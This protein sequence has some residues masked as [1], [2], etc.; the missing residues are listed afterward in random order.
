MRFIL[1]PLTGWPLSDDRKIYL[2]DRE[3]KRV[4]GLQHL[5][6]LSLPQDDLP[7]DELVSRPYSLPD[8]GIPL[9]DSPLQHSDGGLQCDD[10]SGRPLHSLV[11]LEQPDLRHHDPRV[12]KSKKR[13]R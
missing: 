2:P 6:L 4:L 13:H 3:G 7:S 11:Q 1:T 10:I 12:E 5:L 9:G 8:E